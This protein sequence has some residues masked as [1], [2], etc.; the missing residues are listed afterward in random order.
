M[1]TNAA[2]IVR[3]FGVGDAQNVRLAAGATPLSQSGQT[4]SGAVWLANGNTFEPATVS[5]SGNAD[6][7]TYTLGARSADAQATASQMI[8]LDTLIAPT[9]AALSGEYGIVSSWAVT[10]SGST[11]TGTYGN[12]CTWSATLSPN[13]KTIDVTNIEF[14]TAGMPLN[15]NGGTCDYVGKN[16]T[17]TAFLTGPSQAYPK[18]VFDIL[19]DDSAS[20]PVPTTLSMFNFIK[21]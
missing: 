12:T 8:P 21:Q 20:S 16:Y 18:G 1:T 17:G 19:F 13:A 3:A 5:V 15:P 4:A 9:P 11:L 10:I 14:Q 7:A 2:G 6:G